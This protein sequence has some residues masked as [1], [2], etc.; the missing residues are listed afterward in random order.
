MRHHQLPPKRIL[1]NLN[2]VKTFVDEDNNGIDDG[3]DGD[4]ITV[5]VKG[6]ILNKVATFTAPPATSQTNPLEGSN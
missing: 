3:V 5:E 4:T 1:W 6:L 2:F